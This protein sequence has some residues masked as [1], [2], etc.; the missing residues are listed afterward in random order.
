[1]L[2]HAE[3]APVNRRLK[4][5]SRMSSTF[6]PRRL[7]VA[8]LLTLTALLAAP[9]PSHAKPA[10]PDVP[11]DLKV[12]EG[13][14]VYLVGHAVGVQIYGCTLS[15]SGTTWTLLAPRA[16][17]YGDNG[18]L[19]ATHFAGPTWQAIDGSRVVGKREAGVTVDPTAIPWLKLS[20]ASTTPG[21]DG[22]R[23]AH[24]TFIQRVNTTGGLPP[25]ASECSAASVGA[26]AE[27]PYTADYYFWR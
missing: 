18:R 25:A 9:Y 27:I 10:A 17:L 1:M 22:E 21:A 14:S 5:I 15:S 20:A 16:D 13:N 11:T 19:V 7:L 3:H 26:Q 4:E 12:P 8:G 2:R 24:T 6:R 23:L